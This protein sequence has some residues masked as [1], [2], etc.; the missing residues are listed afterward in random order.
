MNAMNGRKIYL[1]FYIMKTGIS[2]KFINII[3]IFIIILLI[4]SSNN[5]T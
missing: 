3:D 1:T 4:I 2:F 5:F